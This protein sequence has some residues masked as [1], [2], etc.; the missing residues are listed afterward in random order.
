MDFG[1]SIEY[2]NSYDVIRYW[3]AAAAIG[4]LVLLGAV[5]FAIGLWSGCSELWSSNEEKCPYIAKSPVYEKRVRIAPEPRVQGQAGEGG[6]A[7]QQQAVTGAGHTFRVEDKITV[8]ASTRW[9]QG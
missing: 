5:G 6:G 1:N 9:L 8:Q 4:G 2:R 3:I 7:E